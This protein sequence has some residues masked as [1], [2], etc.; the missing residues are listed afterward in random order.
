MNV[1]ISLYGALREADPEGALV[2]AVP[3]GCTIGQLRDQLVDFLATHAPQ[4]SVGVVRR[5][6]FATAD[7]ILHDYERVPA[8]GELAILP[9]VSGG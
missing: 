1:H 7:T 2:L 6:A 4:V 8:D 3:D 9:P 5:S